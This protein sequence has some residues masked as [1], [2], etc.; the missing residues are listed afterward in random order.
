MQQKMLHGEFFAERNV[1][2]ESLGLSQTVY[3]LHLFFLVAWML[4]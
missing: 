4:E 2:L 1:A 3:S